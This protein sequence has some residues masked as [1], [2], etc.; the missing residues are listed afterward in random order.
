MKLQ[1]ENGR[2]FVQSEHG[3]VIAEIDFPSISEDKV[4]ICHTFVD[5]SLRGQGIADE[6]MRAAV[7]DLR[8]KKQKAVATCSYASV[9]FDGHPE[10]SDLLAEPK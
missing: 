7:K 6:L 1:H 2:I 10:E 9:W 3:A 8:E 5:K 4:N